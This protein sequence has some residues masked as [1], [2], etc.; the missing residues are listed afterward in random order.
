MKCLLV[1]LLYF[2]KTSGMKLKNLYAFY[3]SMLKENPV[4]WDDGNKCWVIYSHAGCKSILNNPF[5]YIPSVGPKN[6]QM[7]NIYASLMTSQFV[8]LSNGPQHEIARH[9]AGLLFEKTKGID[10]K[11]IADQ[12]M[13]KE[14]KTN[15]IDWVNTICKKLPVLA[16]LKCFGFNSPDCDLI[17]SRSEQLV[18]I[19]LDNKT[20]EQM[21]LINEAAEEIFRIAEKHLLKSGF[22]EPVIITLSKIYPNENIISWCVSNLIGLSI[23]QGYDANRGLLSN[24][25]LQILKNSHLIS[26][27]ITDR[28]YLRKLV[29]ETLRFDPPVHNTKR[30]AAN[31]IFIEDQVIKKNEEILLVL[32]AANR[33]PAIFTRPGIFDVERINNTE[34]LTFGFGRHA[35][36]ASDFAVNLTLETLTYFFDRYKTIKLLE[37]NILYEPRVNVRLPK[38]ILISL[39]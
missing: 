25:L 3:E 29:I 8:R 28:G 6:D 1:K 34:H 26:G 2:V 14:P 19:M 22:Y 35:C 13:R 5:A 7:F 24:S 18:K 37:E 30:I 33:D 20:A 15:E 36:M 10:I 21:I 23:I 4:C 9:T 38:S 12:L 32:A 27:H 31:D 16:V 39:S 17:L 11:D